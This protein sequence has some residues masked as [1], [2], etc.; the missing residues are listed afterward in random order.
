MPS[1]LRMRSC[2]IFFGV[3]VLLLCAM[4]GVA[5]AA[6]R[7]LPLETPNVNIGTEPQSLGTIQIS[8]MNIPS[9]MPFIDRQ[10]P[11]KFSVK[12][13][14]GS[15]YAVTPAPG[16]EAS[17]I[18]IPEAPG[19]T[20]NGFNPGDIQIDSAST[21]TTLVV[22]IHKRS[23]DVDQAVINLLFN[24]PH[25]K[26]VIDTGSGNFQVRIE[27]MF[28]SIGSIGAI[29][30]TD[31][32]NAYLGNGYVTVQVMDI[33][34]LTPGISKAPANIRLVENLPGSIQA[35]KHAISLTLPPGM[36]WNRARIKLSGGF[37]DGDVSI[38]PVK[39]IDFDQEGHSRLWLDVNHNSLNLPW[40]MLPKHSND[41][42]P[43]IIEIGPYVNISSYAE[44]GDMIIKIGGPN[45]IINPQA[46]VAAAVSGTENQASPAV[47]AS[48][49]STFVI[50]EGI[51]SLN[52]INVVMEAAPYIKD[53]RTYMPL[54]YV[55]MALG[56]SSDGMYWD[57]TNQTATL[58]RGNQVIQLQ[59][60][61][62][63]LK[64]NDRISAYLDV[65][66]EIKNGR[67]MLPI[68]I[69]AEKLGGQVDWDAGRQEVKITY[70]RPS[71][72][73]AL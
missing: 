19:T 56:V 28:T 29:A 62:T 51:F 39:G 1:S 10:V 44:S 9:L 11:F 41:G 34:S 18:S 63:L 35:S 43:G 32:T 12:L 36:T 58:S 17:Y 22:A 72:G 53:G 23:R 38:D 33:P 47:E 6:T 71:N 65:A 24:T 3:L 7:I 5:N 52:G 73:P 13:P 60:G 45:Q 37:L 68:G 21:N 31:V 55:A 16:D 20:P 40:P 15:R 50:G 64:V 27:E 66:P 4:P 30:N 57:S 25:S 70:P 61:S 42:K 54:A 69:I 48:K 67:T 59:I 46:I 49:T 2:L 14:S 8:E 26:V